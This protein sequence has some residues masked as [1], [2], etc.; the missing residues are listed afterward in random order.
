MKKWK[1]IVII[2]IVLILLL[3]LCDF[4]Y[5]HYRIYEAEKQINKIARNVANI[6]EKEMHIIEP[7]QYNSKLYSMEWLPETITTT[8]DYNNWKKLVL[9]RGKYLDGRILKKES[10]V[11]DIK[12]CEIKYEYRYYPKNKST[13]IYYEYGN[14]E[15]V[16]EKFIQH[17][18]SY[19]VPTKYVAYPLTK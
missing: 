7:V 15:P 17:N 12:S 11:N 10:E 14:N 9:K 5:R 19:S 16:S 18:F 4:I 3:P 1:I 6:P 2:L 8:K 13:Q